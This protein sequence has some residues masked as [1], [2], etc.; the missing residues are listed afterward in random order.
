MKKEAHLLIIIGFLLVSP[1]SIGAQNK[2]YWARIDSLLSNA[3]T[4]S[5]NGIIVISEKGNIKYSKI[6]GYSDLDKKRPLDKHS[7]FVIGSI[8]KQFTAV[9]VLQELEKG[10]L[11]LFTPIGRYLPELK[12]PWTDTVTIHHLLTHMHGVA[13]IDRPALFKAGTRFDYS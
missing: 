5:F 4:D 13:D 2:N 6:L 3:T 9:M 11:D 12:Q 7:Q 1:K 10:H 8:S